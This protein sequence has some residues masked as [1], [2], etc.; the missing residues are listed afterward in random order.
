MQYMKYILIVDWLKQIVC[1]SGTWDGVIWVLER[2]GR[3]RGLGMAKSCLGLQRTS[4][5]QICKGSRRLHLAR[6][7]KP[8]KRG[9]K[10]LDLNLWATK[11]D[12]GPGTLIA[13][14]SEIAEFTLKPFL[15]E[16]VYSH[17]HLKLVMCLHFP[18]R[19]LKNI[20]KTTSASSLRWL[21]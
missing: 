15:Y 20:N 8:K 10:N 18:S 7:L 2:R 17:Y 4:K 13:S 16:Y 6:W 19:T 5:I 9:L 12:L 14:N 11:I 21:I 3:Q 1:A